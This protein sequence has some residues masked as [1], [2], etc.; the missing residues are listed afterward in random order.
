MHFLEASNAVHKTVIFFKMGRITNTDTCDTIIVKMSNGVFGAVSVVVQMLK[1]PNGLEL[2]RV[3][4]TNGIYGSHIWILYK[5]ICGQKINEMSAIIKSMEHTNA[6]NVMHLIA[7]INLG[8][9][10]E[11]N[12]DALK[13]VPPDFTSVDI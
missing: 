9:S 1:E 12:L 10:P 13:I 2:L 4:D 8:E 5:N 6:K 11:I 3:L 7:Q